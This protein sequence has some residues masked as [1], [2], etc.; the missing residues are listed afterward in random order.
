MTRF[1]G[2]PNSPQ[3]MIVL[4]GILI[5]SPI[6]AQP[7]GSIED[8]SE[9][10]VFLA[11][12]APIFMRVSVTVDG[13]DFRT[14]LAE[15]MFRSLDSDKSDSLDM[16]EFRSIPDGIISLSEIP[17]NEE[18][19]EDGSQAKDETNEAANETKT[20]PVADPG[21]SP[22]F[23]SA[24]ENHDDQLSRSEFVAFMHNRMP[25]SFAIFQKA[26][27]SDRVVKILPRLDTNK[28]A[29]LSPEEVANGIRSL[30]RQDYDDDQTLSA[31]ELLPFRDPLNQ[32]IQADFAPADLPFIRVQP[33][34]TNNEIADRIL[35]MYGVREG[36]GMGTT[37]SSVHPDRLD[38]P[39]PF[40]RRFDVDQNGEWNR[41][42]LLGFL[43]APVHQLLLEITLGARR[44]S[45]E[46]S[47]RWYRTRRRRPK[48]SGEGTK[49]AVEMGGLL[50]KLRI[51][52]SAGFAKSMTR[53]N[54]RFFRS[55]F[56]QIDGGVNGNNYL[57]ETEFAQLGMQT[58]FQTVDRDGD[59]M[60]MKEEVMFWVERE[61]LTST[62]RVTCRVARDGRSLFEM[63]DA[64]R[65]RRLS[66]REMKDGFGR[67][68]TLDRDGDEHVA[69]TEIRSEYELRFELG[70]P[71]TFANTQ[72][73][74][75]GGDMDVRIPQ[76]DN[77][78]GPRWY[79]RMDH[80][81][82]GDISEREFL[83]PPEFFDLVDADD[84]GLISRE[85]AEAVDQ[86]KSA[87]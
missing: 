27:R 41:E 59:G 43:E 80:N 25:N 47:A 69:A 61:A 77:L 30:G 40:F 31:T 45:S 56:Y 84:D 8:P 10:I 4:A 12:D 35:N 44:A 55:R 66:P 19:T 16:G 6:F 2:P 20:Q 42:E 60:I 78:R 67:I 11:P 81:L 15:S 9:T 49:L 68:R 21:P 64:N 26:Q 17:T 34:T 63:L 65:D 33:G 73:M 58:D 50:V 52:G 39:P 38:V 13:S 71:A 82:D 72:T 87:G 29:R 32:N 28:D 62:S 51:G 79:Q 83:G 86:T 46:F 53:D 37:P 1:Q 76:R 14:W 70:R 36:A 75:A 74:N 48:P 23:L 7:G 5:A 85:E 54:Q 24:D 22:A 18:A 57:D 3:L